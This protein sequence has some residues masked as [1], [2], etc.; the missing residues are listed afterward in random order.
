MLTGYIDVG[1]GMRGVYGAGVLD[2]CIDD[3]I[4]FPYYIGVSAGSANIVSFLA[5]QRGRCLRF[6][7]DYSSRRE[8]MSLYNLVKNKEYID[9]DYVYTTLTQEGGEDPIDYDALMKNKCEFYIVSTDAATGK[10]E[11][12]DFKEL[13]QNDFFEIKASCCI[14]L[15]SKPIRRNGRTFFDGGLSDPIPVKRALDSGCDKIVVT[16]TRPETYH[17]K[18]WMSLK[19]AGAVPGK[20]PEM[21][22]LLK[23]SPDRY[24]DGL[25]FLKKLE[26]QGKALVIAPESCCGVSTLS[27]N[28]E[29]IL[30]LYKKGYED[31][32]RIADFLK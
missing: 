4:E 18:H 6:Y 17:K 5:G 15:V 32:G 3:K 27:R 26:A 29:N 24:N 19:A 12:F 25:E 20:Y 22:K 30:A 31:A 8:Y 1:G 14:P 21:A 23:E 10:T 11:Y 2:R 7:R 16:L 28:K 9:L 13:K